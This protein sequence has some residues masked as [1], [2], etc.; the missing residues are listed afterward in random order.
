MINP[1]V[2]TDGRKLEP[3]AWLL[4]LEFIKDL[5]FKYGRY[6]TDEQAMSIEGEYSKRWCVTGGWDYMELSKIG[7]IEQLKISIS[8]SKREVSRQLILFPFTN[9]NTP[10]AILAAVQ[11]PNPIQHP[12]LVVTQISLSPTVFECCPSYEHVFRTIEG[13]ISSLETVSMSTQ[14]C[15]EIAY[16]GTLS[17][18]DLVTVALPKTAAELHSLQALTR[19]AMMLQLDDLRDDEFLRGDSE[20]KSTKNIDDYPRQACAKVET[21]LAFQLASTDIFEGWKQD[22]RNMRKQGED[23]VGD[24]RDGFVSPTTLHET[25][26]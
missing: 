3:G 14:D 1:T 23:A 18:P 24:R 7:T 12:M 21:V 6:F 2:D 15:P 25:C 11:D 13:L 17:A 26:A 19:H 20:K 4:R 8:H 22:R 10:E 16:F 5:S 9:P